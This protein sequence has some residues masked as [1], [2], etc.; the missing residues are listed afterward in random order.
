MRVGSG[1]RPAA[2]VTDGVADVLPARSPSLTRRYRTWF[3]STGGELAEILSLFGRHGERM[4]VRAKSG[5][6]RLH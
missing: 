3:G 5:Q 4:H 6:D 2:E 1:G